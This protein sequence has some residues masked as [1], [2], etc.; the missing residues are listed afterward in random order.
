MAKAPT[1]AK[2]SKGQ[3]DNTNNATKSSMTQRL[4]TDLGQSVGGTTVTQ[5]VWF[6]GLTGPTFPLR[7]IRGSCLTER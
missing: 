6:A 5:V 1:Q 7:I 3:S 4:R 2:M